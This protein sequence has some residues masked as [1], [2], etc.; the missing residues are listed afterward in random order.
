LRE[1]LRE[2]N[3]GEPFPLKDG[4]GSVITA[5]LGG[6]GACREITERASKER[7]GGGGG[8]KV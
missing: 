2:G 5:H 3:V 7:E 8:R 4:A 6:E 1:A